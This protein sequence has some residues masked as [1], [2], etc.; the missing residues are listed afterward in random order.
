MLAAASLGVATIA[1]AALAAQS[2]FLRD[3]FGIS[4]DRQLVCGISFGYSNDAHVVNAFRTGRAA[5]EEVVQW[6]QE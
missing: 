1:Q 5:Q 2:P 4:G 6:I 3:W